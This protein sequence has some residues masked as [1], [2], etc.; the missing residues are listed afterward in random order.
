[1]SDTPSEDAIR[2]AEVFAPGMYMREEVAA[3]GMTDAQFAEAIGRPLNFVRRLYNGDEPL[4]GNIAI[5]VA[6]A[7]DMGPDLWLRMEH[8]YRRGLKRGIAD[9]T[10]RV[11]HDAAAHAECPR[12][13]AQ[14][15][16]LPW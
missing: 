13:H 14:M 7:F 5:R 2:P 3:R 11:A 16:E 1:M 9:G 15:K 10:E 12:C 8:V 6:R 4:L